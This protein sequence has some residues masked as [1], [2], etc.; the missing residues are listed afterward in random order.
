MQD[1]SILVPDKK[2]LKVSPTLA[3]PLQGQRLFFRSPATP[4]FGKRITIFMKNGDKASSIHSFVSESKNSKP[5]QSLTRSF[6]WSSTPKNRITPRDKHPNKK[7]RIDSNL[8]LSEQSTQQ[9]VD[10]F[11]AQLWTSILYLDWILQDLCQNKFMKR[12]MLAVSWRPWIQVEIW[13]SL[14]LFALH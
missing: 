2:L 14:K 4:V 1:W 12:K 9:K 5:L 11:S 8:S 13:K 3:H 10:K 7:T 6:M